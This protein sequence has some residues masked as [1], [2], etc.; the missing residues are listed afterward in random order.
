MTQYKTIV[1]Q[2]TLLQGLIVN[3]SIHK[4]YGIWDDKSLF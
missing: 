3:E 2:V 4:V 1:L